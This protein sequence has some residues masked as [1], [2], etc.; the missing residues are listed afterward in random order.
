MKGDRGIRRSITTIL[1]ST[2]LDCLHLGDLEQ[3]Y[4]INTSLNLKATY[5]LLAILSFYH[6]IMI[7]GNVC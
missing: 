2:V 6:A 3:L 1:S 7:S 4:H 5:H